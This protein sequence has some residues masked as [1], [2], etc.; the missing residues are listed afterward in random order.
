MSV[1]VVYSLRTA[2]IQK[3][4]VRKRIL[5]NEKEKKKNEFLPTTA[6]KKPLITQ[7]PEMLFKYHP[8]GSRGVRME[9]FVHWISRAIELG[10]ISNSCSRD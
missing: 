3:K 10:I 5:E 1:R 8:D 2:D 9:S 7:Q 4:K 6:T